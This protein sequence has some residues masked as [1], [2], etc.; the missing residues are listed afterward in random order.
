MALWPARTSELFRAAAFVLAALCGCAATVPVRPHA[1]TPTGAAPTVKQI[2]DVL[3]A[4]DRALATFRAQARLDYTSPQQ[5]FRSTQ[6]IVVGAP[7]SA[8]IDVIHPFGVSY[9][10]ATDGK[11]LSAYDRRKSVFYEGQAGAES[12]RHF[13]G[14]PLGATELAA[15]LRGVPP[16]L[17]DKRWQPVQPTEGGWLLRRVLGGGGTLEF[18]VDANSYEPLRVKISGDRDRHEVEVA[19]E[20]YRDV[21]GIR[22]PYRI[23][24]SFRDGSHLELEYQNVQRG[25]VLA[26]EA[27]H[28]DRPA[29]ARSV[30][31]D[32][33][34]TGG[35]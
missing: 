16:A 14:V 23:N 30:N 26:D 22:V 8:R 9:T 15:V 17:G 6:V 29:G 13:I 20:D 11:Q 34:G 27:F 19:Y 18:V 32:T 33:E 2:T 28:I 1:P 4:R 12:F 10:V 31:I 35:T 3:Q 24:V 7:S 25:V 21:S 5:S